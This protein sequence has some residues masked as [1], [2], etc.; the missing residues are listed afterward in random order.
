MRLTIDPRTEQLTSQRT[1][2]VG[3]NDFI[4]GEPFAYRTGATHQ[5]AWALLCFVAKAGSSAWKALL[6]RGLVL[7]GFKMDVTKSPHGQKLPYSILPDAETS[8]A[9]DEFPKFMFVRHPISRLLSGYLGKG[10][11]GKIKVT[12]WNHSTGFR[13]FVHAVTSANSSQANS[14]QADSSLDK[15]FKLQSEQCGLS[16]GIPYRVLRVEDMGHWYRSVVCQLALQQAVQFNLPSPKLMTAPCGADGSRDRH[17]DRRL[18]PS[19]CFVRTTDC[20]CRIDCRGTSRCNAS[21]A[22]THAT[23]S[24]GSLNAA[25]DAGLLEKYY[26]RELAERVN[27]WARADLEA[28]GYLPWLPGQKLQARVATVL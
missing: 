15:H 4:D 6:V 8:L 13:S 7:Q 16:R 2:T 26:D 20:G 1:R 11:R 22:G 24:F 19:C 9:A 3:N 28:F 10:V 17:Q 25:S 27:A 14:S 23:A 5:P 18:A 21:R 12:G